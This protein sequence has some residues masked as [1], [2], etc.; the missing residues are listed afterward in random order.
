MK[1]LENYGLVE[2]NA[3]EIM[4]IDGGYG[5]GPIFTCIYGIPVPRPNDGDS[6]SG[7]PTLDNPI[8]QGF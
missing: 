6:G 5:W 3:A 8:F 1:K 2:L 7:Q 4:N